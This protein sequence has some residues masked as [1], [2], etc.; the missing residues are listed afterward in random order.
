MKKMRKFMALLIATIMMA[1]N[2]APAFATGGDEPLP[3][4]AGEVDTCPAVSG[5]NIEVK[6]VK[7]D[8]GKSAADL[9]KNPDQ[10][11]I[12][13]L[14]TDYL[15]QR[16]EEYEINSQPYIASVGAAA[17]ADEQKKVAQTI[18]LP[19][20]PGY[21]KPKDAIDSDINDYKITYDIVKDAA[22]GKSETGN[23]EDGFKYQANKEFKYPG[24]KVQF[25]VKHVFQ[26][27][28]DFT[29][30]T[31]L[32]GTITSSDGTLIDAKG[33][34]SKVNENEI[35]KHEKVTSKDGIAGSK[36]IVE[37]L[38][39]EKREGFVPEQYKIEV[40]V[41]EDT[42]DFILEYRY[43]RA[44]Y[45]VVFDT[46]GGTELPARTLYYGQVI[47]KI[48]DADIP[49]KEG[50]EFQGWKPSVE[51]KTKDGQTF[52]ANE[53]IADATGSAI[54]NLYANLIMPAGKVTFTAVW[55]DKEKAGY[56]IQ[57]WAEKADHAD[58]AGLLDKYDYIGTRVY[59]DQATG[60]RPDLDNEPVKDIVFPDLDKARLNKIW[61]GAKFNRGQNL[62]LN[63]FYVYNQDLTREQNADPADVNLVKSVDSTGKTVYNIYYDR[64]VYDLYF[65]KSN[66]QP[67]ANTFYPE[68]WGYDEAQGEV[69]KKG[70]PGNPYHYKA[71]FNQLMTG[72]PNDAM[73]TKGFSEGMQSFG[74][75]PNYDSPIW[76]VH[77]DTPPYR[78]NADEFLDMENY[79]RW[80]GYTK[81]ID[82]GDGT[83]INLKW[84]EFTTLSFGIKQAKDSM[85]HH[86]DF[87]MD[88]FKDDETIIRYDLYRFKADTNSDTYAPSYPKVQGFTGKRA[89]ETP[90]YLDSDGIDAKN[91]ERAEVTPFPTKTYTD[92][93]G[94]RPVGEMKFIKAFFNNGDEWG[95]PDGWDGFDNNGY[96]KF[97]YTR[98]KYKLRFNYDP[99]VIKGDSDFDNTNSIDTFYEFPLKALSPELEGNEEYKKENPANLLDNPEKLKELKLSGLVDTDKDGKLI[100]KR[101]DGLSDQMVF[102]GWALDPAGTKLIRENPGETMPNHPVNLYAK[103]GE[104]DYKWNVT[105]DPNGGELEAIEETEVT[106]KTKTIQEGD[107]G[108]EVEKNYP[109]KETKDA[110][111]RD[112]QIFT[113]VQRQKLVEPA[114]KPKRKGYDFMGWE[115]I[116]Y[117]K[118]G[119]GNYT[120]EQD[121]SYRNEY[122]V[123]E[124]Y[125]FGNDVVA[126]VYLKAIWTP[127]QRVDVDVEHYF[128]DKD[129]NLDA[130][131]KSNPVKETLKNVRVNYMASTIGDKQ[132]A[133]YI[134]APHSELEKKLTGDL[135]ATYEE[136]N[137][138]VGLNNSY[139]QTFRV[140]PAMIPDP[141]DSSK[142]KPNPEAEDNIFKFFY[143]PFRKREY[144]VNYL[145]ERAEA[146]LAEAKTDAEKK[147]IIEKY[148][149]AGQ[150]KVINGN[151]HFDARNY[152]PIPGWKLVSAPQ[153]QLF[154]DV[155]E[156]TNKLLGI[157]GT[158][159]D[160]INFYYKDVRVIEV[161]ENDPVPDGYVRVTFKAV[162]NG[163]LEEDGKAKT[164]CYDVI[165]GLEFSNIPV[166]DT[167]EYKS[168]K[169]GVEIVPNK[170]YQ[171]VGWE[172]EEDQSKGL[173]GNDKG[174][175]ENYTYV[176][177]F[178]KPQGKITITKVLENKPVE[179][180][181]IMARMAALVP[182]KFTF[183]VTGPEINGSKTVAPKQYEEEIELAAGE[184]ITLDGLFDG[185]YTVEETGANGYTPYYVDGEYVKGSSKLSAKPIEVEIKKTDNKKDYEKILTVVNKNVKPEKPGETNDNIINI[186][187]KKVWKGGKKPATKIE[188]WRKGY[189]AEYKEDST[190]EEKAKA[191]IDE[192]VGD[193]TTT[194]EGD[195]EQSHT[196]NDL[197]K[198]DPSGREFVYYAKEPKVPENYELTD[199]DDDKLTITN[200]YKIPKTEEDIIGKKIWDK[201]PEGSETPTVKLELWRKTSDN[202]DPEKAVDKAE[203]LDA[204]NQ[205]NFSKQD[206]TDKDG[207]DYTYFVKEVFDDANEQAKWT[208]S[209]E[210]TL[211]LTNTFKTTPAPATYTVTF[212]NKDHGAKPADQKVEAGKTATEPTPA[213]TADGFDF[214][215]WYT[216]ENFGHK[217]NFTTPVNS[218]ITL[219]AKWTAKTVT[220]QPQPET[221]TIKYISMDEQMGKVSNDHDTGDTTTGTINGSTATANEGYKFVHWLG[222]DGN[223]YTVA[224]LVPTE[225]K[226][227]T[228]IAIFEALPET[229]E[230]DEIQILYIPADETMG[231]VDLAK[232][233][234]A[235]GG[236]IQ[237]ST[238]TAKPG[239]KF[240]Q[241]IDKDGNIVSDQPTFTPNTNVSAVYVAMFEKDTT[242]TPPT[243]PTPGGNIPGGGTTRPDPNNPDDGKPEDK[244]GEK[245]EDKPGEKP[246]DKPGEKPEDKPGEKPDDKP[247][248]PD[249]KPYKPSSGKSPKKTGTNIITDVRNFLSPKTGIVSNYELYLGLMAA[250]SVGLFFTR[251]KKNKDEE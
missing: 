60:T 166:P 237:G 198:H 49:T 170:D 45:D 65:T 87:W 225:K 92:M 54:K 81:K 31:N 51:L 139:F 52:K 77:L 246:E 42:K 57:F 121:D 208:V 149:I 190:N 191:Q 145:D 58:N 25:E 179:K 4:P 229:P 211:E 124:L 199:S 97:E 165:K 17:T 55:K 244:P 236:I 68:I 171:F 16:G 128:L 89:N 44:H 76:P 7:P 75:G 84:N 43:N 134:L 140:K 66:A 69:V 115:V 234:V 21:D 95:D 230:P 235:K 11:A 133:D 147:A 72:W 109:K 83:S 82:K 41:P 132:D 101:P 15:V 40:Q 30:Y 245:P 249:D 74:W 215:G 212:D 73:Q 142:M 114:E 90:E 103:W 91:E 23:K 167:M 196:F 182:M 226:N 161:P 155:E 141:D 151:R 152:K 48:A 154:F 117:T 201:V 163:K 67:A 29:K 63:K 130:K 176:A 125:S 224:E 33:N 153:Q 157:N 56:A 94:E 64:Q 218:D 129:Y 9:I 26:D 20:F 18:K 46:Q 210:G 221:F 53:I 200:N 24:K 175:C 217:Y 127:N 183:K 214:G 35:K 172:R 238:A 177:K 164:V 250:S 88:G 86:M 156:D 80:G 39:E 158:G 197:P 10:P 148:T 216:D 119:N 118:D 96:L 174:V 144:K 78:L 71:R 189:K 162:K 32:D 227:A 207:I 251:E 123:P 19:E 1:S 219:Y 222:T 146:E 150:E 110:D 223:T 193:F 105:F 168:E 85:P 79:D 14:R 5:S 169:S 205:V 112:K 36:I 13:T 135:K 180:K 93:Y 202:G 2:I 136:Y 27:L 184:S 126:P 203:A 173:L 204:Q 248:K 47:P 185:K 228:Y 59:N 102:K 108:Q 239:Y 186:T 50:G 232:E 104:P 233:E 181:S 111:K 206:K 106:Q 12:Y 242:V 143:R 38:E 122:R 194:P 34:E 6:P 22:N 192:K 28:E 240:L 241:W 61:K 98:N 137:N 120:D 220:P 8:N 159:S 187:V 99:S 3:S 131:K 138:R 37:P 195:K 247:A 113:V 116:R 188:L 209:G 160:E 213:L 243:P 178:E 100:V 107:I 231:S 62:Y 70:G